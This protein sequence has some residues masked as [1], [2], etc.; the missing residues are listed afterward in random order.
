MPGLELL[1]GLLN[2][3][4]VREEEESE[5]GLDAPSRT[6]FEAKRESLHVNW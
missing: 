4:F 6:M 2:G 3:A 5:D 1:L